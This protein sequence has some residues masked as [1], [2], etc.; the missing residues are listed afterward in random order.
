M[1]DIFLLLTA[2]GS[3][4][5]HVS[6]CTLSWYPPS[7]RSDCFLVCILYIFIGVPGGAPLLKRVKINIFFS[8]T[9][10]NRDPY[11]VLKGQWLSVSAL[12]L[13]VH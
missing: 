13:N 2:L 8:V 1:F 6:F 11:S 7:T 4:P 3:I 12:W 5:T 10:F 9:M